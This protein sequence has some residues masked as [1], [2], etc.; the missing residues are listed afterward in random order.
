MKKLKDFLID[1]CKNEGSLLG[2]SILS[3]TSGMS[4]YNYFASARL[5]PASNLKILTAVAALRK[6]DYDYTFQT[7][8]YCDGEI[9]N[10]GCHGNIYLVG[11]GDPTYS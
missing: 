4:L 5:Q 6:L 10:K 9:V 8:V 7:E 11:K 2:L 3:G 1:K